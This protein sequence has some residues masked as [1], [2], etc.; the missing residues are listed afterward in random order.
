MPRLIWVFAGRTGHFV[1]FVFRWLKYK[2]LKA[3]VK[4]RVCKTKNPLRFL[5]QIENSIT[6]DNCWASWG[7]PVT[8]PTEFSIWDSQPLK[9]LIVCF[10]RLYILIYAKFYLDT[11]TYV[12]VTLHSQH[13]FFI[14]SQPGII[15]TMLRNTFWWHFL[16]M[17]GIHARNVLCDITNCTSVDATSESSN[18]GH[19]EVKGQTGAFWSWKSFVYHLCNKIQ[20]NLDFLIQLTINLDFLIQLTIRYK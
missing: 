3:I 17:L 12:E 9:I 16:L 13:L 2:N 6:S 15:C 11:I 7:L 20:V 18:Q 19:S 14:Y 8:L 5:V 4:G 1:G 10:K